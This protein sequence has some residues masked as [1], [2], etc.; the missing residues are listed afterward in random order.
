MFVEYQFT[1][2]VLKCIVSTYTATQKVG[3]LR[4]NVGAESLLNIGAYKFEESPVCNYP[5]TVILSSLPVFVT[6]KLPTSNFDITK[7]IDLSLIGSY[8][9]TIRSEIKVPNDFT[10]TSFTTMFDQYQF[11]VFVEPC[12]VSFYTDTLKVADINYNIGNKSLKNTG[13]YTFDE[14][15]VCNYPET[16]KLTNLPTFVT[17]NAPNTADFSVPF[18]SDLSLIG[19]YTV[20]IRSEINVPKDYTKNTF[21]NMFVEYEFK[22]FIQ[23]CLVTSYDATKAITRIVYNVNQAT[24]TSGNYQFDEFPVCNYPEVVTVTN[25]PIWAQHN[26]ASSDFTIPQ[27]GNLSLVG[28]YTVTL[29]SEIKIPTDHTKTAFKTLFVEYSFPI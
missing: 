4:Y 11:T 23:P 14:S 20:T 1:V 12:L 17:H 5:K 13:Q 25:L 6:H 26:L 19:S 22:V 18:S 15:P 7:T 9:V 28:S 21:K 24:L 3:D 27:N 29:R 8:V 16:V 10:G 2:E